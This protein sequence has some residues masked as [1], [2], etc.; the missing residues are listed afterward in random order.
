MLHNFRAFRGSISLYAFPSFFVFM[1]PLVLFTASVF[2]RSQEWKSGVG[3][4]ENFSLRKIYF[5]P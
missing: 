1:S 2:V 5:Q 3:S 4:E